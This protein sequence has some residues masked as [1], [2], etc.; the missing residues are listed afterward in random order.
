M[1]EEIPKIKF[2]KDG[3]AKRRG[4]PAML[5]ISCSECNKLL[6]GYQKD[7]PGPLIRCYLDRI[8]YPE[9]LQSILSNCTEKNECP[10]LECQNCNALIGV[11]MVYEKENRLAYL[12]KPGAFKMKKV[13]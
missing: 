2:K 4:A 8:H 10:N 1:I 5:A 6:M 12:L 11:P 7:G 9:R 3:Y 13:Y